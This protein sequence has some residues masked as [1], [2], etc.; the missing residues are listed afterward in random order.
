MILYLYGENS[1]AISQQARIIRQKYIDTTGPEGDMENIDVAEK[2]IGTLLGGLSVVPMFVSS[3]LIIA[4][5]L[6]KSKPSSEQLDEIIANTADTT[7]LIIIDPNPDKRTVLYKKLSKLKGAKEFKNLAS[8]ELA[9]WVVLEAKKNEAEISSEDA[10]YLID[11]VGENQWTLSNE[12]EKLANYN[13]K[14]TKQ[15]IDELAVP[16]LENNTFVLTE[17][18]ANK[19]LPRVLNLYKDIKLQ[20][21]AD[22]L[23]LGAI[24]FQYRTILLS[25]LKNNE[26]NRAYKM[27]PYALGKAQSIASK[28]TLDN[29]KNAYAIISEADMNIKTGELTS[30]EAMNKLFYA[31]CSI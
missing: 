23:I 18:L 3:R 31:L 8:Y 27:S 28:Y 20:G 1:F 12:I 11:T 29:V 24:T 14:I 16:S 7:N 21:H 4:S 22:Q 13:S 25:L 15:T 19:D 2:G 10:K 6:A 5:N 30:A 17:A 26:L 9:K